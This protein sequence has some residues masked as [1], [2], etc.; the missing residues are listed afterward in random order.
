[1]NFRLKNKTKNKQYNLKIITNKRI[2]ILNR[3]CKM[4]KNNYFK[5]NIQKLQKKI[6]KI[7]NYENR[8]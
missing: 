8:K 1:M 6:A 3:M 5:G 7:M 4:K 2:V